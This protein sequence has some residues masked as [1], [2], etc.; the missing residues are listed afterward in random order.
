MEPVPIDCLHDGERHHL[1]TADGAAFACRY[2]F[3]RKMPPYVNK[4]RCTVFLHLR[5]SI[6]LNTA[7]YR[8]VSSR[9]R[10]VTDVIGAMRDGCGAPSVSAEIE[11]RECGN[12]PRGV[13]RE[14]CMMW[15]GHP[16]HTV[17]TEG[18]K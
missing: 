10:I 9:R 7:G 1:C 6:R 2:G 4:P 3:S 12:H 13:I 8:P 14:N 11:R 5:L 17:L 15:H 16:C 18:K